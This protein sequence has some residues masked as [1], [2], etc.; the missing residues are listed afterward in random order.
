M[1]KPETNWDETMKALVEGDRVAVAKVSHVVT[2]FLARYG[3]YNIRESWDD[4]CQEVLIALIRRAQK[5]QICNPSAFISYVGKV[6]RSKL[7]D[8]VDRDRRP[9]SASAAIDGNAAELLRACMNPEHDNPDCDIHL[10]LQVALNK[11]PERTRRVLEAIYLEGQRYEDAA[12]MLETKL[13]T[14]KRLQT[15]GLREL[16][17]MLGVELPATARLQMA[18]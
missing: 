2:C 7:I 8:R 17:Q 5:G 15:A 4:I 18:A 1:S 13:G 10:D 3:A 12:Q 16:R 14:L 6:T 9:G 11:L